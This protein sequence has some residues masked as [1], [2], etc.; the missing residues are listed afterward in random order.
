MIMIKQIYESMHIHKYS[1]AISGNE[2]HTI[3]AIFR[4]L[5]HKNKKSSKLLIHYESIMVT[6]T[7][8]TSVWDLLAIEIDLSTMVDV[9]D[10][11]WSIEMMHNPYLMIKKNN[12][13]YESNQYD[14]ASW[15]DHTLCKNI[16]PNIIPSSNESTIYP[17]KVNW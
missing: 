10:C 6:L 4:N 2:L 3:P 16:Y 12:C 14:Q 17:K 7:T 15:P 1:T 13:I 5:S 9:L 8:E 11:I